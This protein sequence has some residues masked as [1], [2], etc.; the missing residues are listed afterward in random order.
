MDGDF[1]DLAEQGTLIAPHIKVL[2]DILDCHS[3][4]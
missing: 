3:L 2:S 4:Q 1:T